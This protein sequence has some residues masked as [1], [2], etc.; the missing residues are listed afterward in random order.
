MI[1]YYLFYLLI[2]YLIY[3][4]RSFFYYS[5]LHNLSGMLCKM[6]TFCR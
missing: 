3:I 6:D 1:C 4:F 2:I 5:Y